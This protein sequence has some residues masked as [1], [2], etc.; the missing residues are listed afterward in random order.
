MELN[1]EQERE[2]T[3][4]QLVAVGCFFA[5]IFVSWKYVELKH[6]YAK[7]ETDKVYYCNEYNKAKASIEVFLDVEK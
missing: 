2:R 1:K 5:L 3:I 7:A 4:Y 6:V